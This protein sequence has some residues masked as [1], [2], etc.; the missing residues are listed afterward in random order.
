MIEIQEYEMH[1]IDNEIAANT[2]KNYLN[3]LRQ[4]DAFLEINDCALSKAALIKF[5]QYLREHEYKPKKH[6]TMK[7]INQK[8]TSINVYLNWLE[9]EEFITDKLSIKLLKA[10]T[11]EHRESI[12]KSD[13]KKL[14]KNCDDEELELFILTIG[15]TGVRITEVCSLKVS[16]LNQK[17]ILVE[18]KGKERAIAMPQFLKKR[19]KKFVRTNGIT[20][21]IFAK[22]Q[23][24]Y[25]ADLK[26]LAGKAKVNKE[27]V[28]P[29]SIRHYFAKAFL[30]NGGDSTVLQQ[31]LGH[32]QIATTTIYTKLNSNELSEQFS[33]IK[34]I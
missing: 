30:E 7:T 33:N 3:T 28:Y 19:L 9:R 27:K 34:N 10:Q 4:L 24:T 20:D 15:N 2:R 31:L 32:K 25:R 18:N 13:Y 11:M 1:L 17:T 29:H 6:Y 22:D 8:I 16:D 14:L 26:N 12:T 21:I 5:K 23:R